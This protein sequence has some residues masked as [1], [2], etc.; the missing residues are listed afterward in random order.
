MITPEKV[1]KFLKHKPALNLTQVE[2]E[3]GLPSRTLHKVVSGTLRLNEKHC[4]FLEPVLREYGYADELFSKAKIISIVNHKGGVGKT[5]TTINLGKA[6][7]ISGFKVLL[8]DF[9]SQGNTSQCCGVHETES[10]VIDALLSKE[11]LPIIPL[12]ENLS[13]SPSNIKMAYRELELINSIGNEKRL[14]N[15]LQKV[16]EDFDFILI[17]CPPA[18]NIFTTNA[19]VA[20]DLCIIPLQPEAS[21]LYGVDSLFNRIYEVREES[22]PTLIVKGILF[23]MVTENTLVHKQM[24]DYVKTEYKHIP[25][26]N[27]FIER[28]TIIQQSQVAQQ[29]I[30]SYSPKSPVAQQY[31]ELAKEFFII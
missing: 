14:K 4:Q 5:T 31:A 21:A 17:D 6:L 20:S 9:D 12:A 16:S 30:F 15:R 2:K 27:I 22:N 24:M 3:A 8:V 19:L 18:L 23:T 1:L 13:L 10:Q 29:D 11:D 28:A 25:I 7:A 26:F